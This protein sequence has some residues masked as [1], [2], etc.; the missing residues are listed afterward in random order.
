MVDNLKVDQTAIL[1]GQN[2]ILI[3]NINIPVQYLDDGLEDV[4]NRVDYFIKKDY[5][6]STSSIYFEIS[7]TYRLKNKE[8][9]A[10]RS[11]LGSFAPRFGP[12]LLDNTRFDNS[13]K[14]LALRIL[15]KEEVIAKLTT[16]NNLE[17]D[18]VFDELFS[19][20]IHVTSIVPK[21]YPVLYQRNL[22]HGKKTT[23]KVA[24]FQLPR[25]T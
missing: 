15:N 4:I 16:F 10:E 18:W 2:F 11:W 6:N 7:A 20:I 22:F 12:S 9:G 17:S 14:P 24:T 8:T 3:S 19:V 25:R 1:S 23:R 5:T 21:E 13:F